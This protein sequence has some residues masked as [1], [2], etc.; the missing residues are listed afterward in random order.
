MGEIKG[1]K[2]FATD[3]TQKLYGKGL[4]FSGFSRGL[5]VERNG[6]MGHAEAGLVAVTAG[7]VVV[8]EKLVFDVFELD[9][10]TTMPAWSEAGVDTDNVER[11]V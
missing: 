9:S 1:T 7:T 11:F 2:T 8:D 10:R 5:Q 3:C 4:E 6:L